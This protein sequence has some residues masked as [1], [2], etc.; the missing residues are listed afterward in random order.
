[1]SEERPPVSEVIEVLKTKT[2][3]KTAKWWCSVLTGRM[4]G[5]TKIFVYLHRYEK[6]KWK[7]K[8]KMTI[9]SRQNWTDIK[10]AVEEQLSTAFGGT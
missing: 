1:M 10:Q 6:E 4:F 3:Y 7:R 2:I 8:G 9:G 5:K